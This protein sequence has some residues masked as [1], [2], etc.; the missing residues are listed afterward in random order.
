MPNQYIETNMARPE[1]MSRHAM[2]GPSSMWYALPHLQAARRGV[3]TKAG[4]RKTERKHAVDVLRKQ[5]IAMPAGWSTWGRAEAF[6]RVELLGWTVGL[7]AREE[8]KTK[9]RG[10]ISKRL[11]RSKYISFKVVTSPAWQLA[12]KECNQRCR[13]EKA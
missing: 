7:M 4:G 12:M 2:V 11:P 5:M 6:V 1:C 8:P 3:D 9:G 10:E 13:F